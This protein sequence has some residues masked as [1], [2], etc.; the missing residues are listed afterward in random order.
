MIYSAI[1]PR[2]PGNEQGMTTALS[3][4]GV[5]LGLLACL[6]GALALFNRRQLRREIR[7]EEEP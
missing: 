7:R 6:L 2:S 5:S 3:I 4:I 1:K